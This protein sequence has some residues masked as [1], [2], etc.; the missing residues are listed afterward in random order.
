M[1]LI[2]LVRESSGNGVDGSSNMNKLV[3]IAVV[4]AVAL[5]AAVCDVWSEEGD[6][7]PEGVRGFS[8]QVRGVVV[9]KAENDTFT[10]RAANV[11]RVWKGNKAET[12]EALAGLTVRVGPRWSKGEDGKWHPAELHVAFIRKIEAG[13]E[14]TL[15][16]R[17]VEGSHFAIL[18]LLAEQ[19][20]LAEAKD[21]QPIKAAGRETGTEVRKARAEA[22]PL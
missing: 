2:Q 20:Q 5:L 22:P 19:R 17:N 14:M 3:S 1:R 4:S 8:G 7:L 16:I 13:Q 12:P 6:A 9:A 15:E 21:A 10:F 11:L 18:E